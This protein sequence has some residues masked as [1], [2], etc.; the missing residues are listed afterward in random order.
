M[1][2]SERLALMLLALTVVVWAIVVYSGKNQEAPIPP[3]AVAVI[4]S[5]STNSEAVDTTA[6]QPKEKQQRKNSSKKREPS[7]KSKAKKEKQPAKHRDHLREPVR[8][9]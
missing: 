4:D 1:F 6:K 9:N 2:T 5:I 8:D 7:K 3:E